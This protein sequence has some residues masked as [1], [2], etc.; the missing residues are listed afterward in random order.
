MQ[1]TKHEVFKHEDY[2][3]EICIPAWMKF[4]TGDFARIFLW[5]TM[6]PI[7]DKANTWMWRL[8]SSTLADITLSTCYNNHTKNKQNTPPHQANK[9]HQL[10]IYD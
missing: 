8:Y 3:A 1:V 6:N 5:Q 2:S 10:V 4:A 7:T 9:T